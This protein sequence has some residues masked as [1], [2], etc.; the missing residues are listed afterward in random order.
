MK[1]LK[2]SNI[3][4]IDKTSIY[5]LRTYTAN[6]VVQLPIQ[7]IDLPI[8]FTI[9]NTPLGGSNLTIELKGLIQYPIIPLRKKLSEYIRE[10]DSNGILPC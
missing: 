7:N 10:I 4:R 8:K 9:E 3:E 6:A 1:I 2:L 5:Y